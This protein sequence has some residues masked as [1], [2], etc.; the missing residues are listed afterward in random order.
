VFVFVARLDHHIL[1]HGAVME[2]LAVTAA[3]YLDIS[4]SAVG[5]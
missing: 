5:G 2:T 4:F 1:S 3:D